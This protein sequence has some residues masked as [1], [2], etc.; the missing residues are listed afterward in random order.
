MNWCGGMIK[1]TTVKSTKEWRLALEPSWC[2]LSHETIATGKGTSGIWGQ[3][4]PFAAENGLNED[5]G[6]LG[7]TSEDFWVVHRKSSATH[8]TISEK[9]P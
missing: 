6:L 3:C 4:F 9:Y 1:Q 7:H 5:S 2:F 8:R